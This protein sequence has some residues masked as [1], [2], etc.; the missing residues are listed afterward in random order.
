M[1]NFLLLLLVFT[2]QKAYSQCDS[3]TIDFNLADK[4]PDTLICT[5]SSA[6]FMDLSSHNYKDQ[7]VKFKW[8][9]GDVRDKSVLQNPA[10]TYL[11]AG[12]YDVSFYAETANGCKDSITKT[13]FITVIGPQIDFKLLND[14]VCNGDS[15]FIELNMTAIGQ[16]RAI[17]KFP[18]TTV[19]VPSKRKKIGLLVDTRTGGKSK[20]SAEVWSKVKDPRTGVEKDCSDQYPFDG[21][22]EDPIVAYIHTPLAELDVDG[23]PST[24]LYL[25]NKNSYSWHYWIF[26][27]DTQRVD[28]F[29]T[30]VNGNLTLVASNDTCQISR[31][32]NSVGFKD[33]VTPSFEMKYSSSAARLTLSNSEETQF[34]VSIFN[35]NGQLVASKN[36][37]SGVVSFDLAGLPN[38]VY[39]IKAQAG[40]QFWNTSILR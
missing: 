27:G 1:K 26:D 31:S 32:W 29:K 20:I 7:S 16:A 35:V 10:H 3:F 22:N 38:S 17:I 39:M 14:S 11:D 13:G 6:A 30:S 12:R 37:S 4:V 36:T 5:P 40:Q 18:G 21:A 34:Q 9:F 25:R 2:V 19:N 28:T 33:P 23:W 24:G 8:S 15:L